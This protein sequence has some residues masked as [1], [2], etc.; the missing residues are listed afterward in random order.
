MR[1]MPPFSRRKIFAGLSALAASRAIA[2]AQTAPILILPPNPLSQARVFPL[3]QLP[4]RKMVNGG[5]SRDVLRGTLTTGEVVAVHESEQ[6]AGTPPNPPHNKRN[7]CPTS[8]RRK[9][10]WA[11]SGDSWLHRL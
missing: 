10:D 1:A 2:R 6:P 5:E 11:T 4:I 9:G 7:P 8:R 3:D